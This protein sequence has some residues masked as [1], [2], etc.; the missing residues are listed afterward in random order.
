MNN[1]AIGKPGGLEIQN[2]TATSAT[3][4]DINWIQLNFSIS[5]YEICVLITETENCSN[6]IRITDE[7]Q[8]YYTI[9]NLQ[10]YT[11]YYV[12]ISANTAGAYEISSPQRSVRTQE[13]RK[14]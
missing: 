3:T 13:Q 7:T 5:Y 14:Q 12:T 11:M 2:I 4:V 10:P 8:I 9:V 6:P 1:I